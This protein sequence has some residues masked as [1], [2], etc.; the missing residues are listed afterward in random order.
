MAQVFNTAVIVFPG[1]EEL[2]FVGVWEVLGTTQHLSQERFFQARTLGTTLDPIKCGHGLTIVADRSIENLSK[3]DVIIVPGGPGISQAMKDKQLLKEIRQAY[4]SGKL[5]CSICTGAF[6]FAE[7]GVL[8]GKKATS[9]HTEVEKLSRYGAVPVRRRVVVE[10]NIITGAGV[11]ASLDVGL[12][13]VEALLGRESAQ[14]V[15]E[16]IEYH[17]EARAVSSKILELI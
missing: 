12:R 17:M 1:V 4:E 14:K 7:A 3:Y 10:D 8:R 9:Y 5:V 2:D 13:I 11:A 15:A 16:W 6:I